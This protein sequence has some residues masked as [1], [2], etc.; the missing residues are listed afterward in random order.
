MMAKQF[1]KYDL[2]YAVKNTESEF[3]T[4]KTMKF[5]GDTM[6][7]YGVRATKIENYKSEIVECWELYRKKSV[8]HGLIESA[9]FDKIT[10]NRIFAKRD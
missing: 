8:K 4:R 2:K 1:T 7:N 6:Q 10:F 5:F 9:Y 3:F